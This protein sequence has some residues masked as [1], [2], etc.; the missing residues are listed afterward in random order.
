VVNTQNNAYLADVV[1]AQGIAFNQPKEQSMYAFGYPA[2][3]PYD[4]KTLTYCS[5]TT[6]QEWLGTGDIG[7]KCTMT[8]GASGGPWFTQFDETLGTGLL[9]SVNSFK[10]NFTTDFMFG[11]YFGTD[12]QDLYNTAKVA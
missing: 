1:G 11:P 5:G 7:L 9:N 3:A 12:A 6:S 2:E 10:Y 8:A 4:G